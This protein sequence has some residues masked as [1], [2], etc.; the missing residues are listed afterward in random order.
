MKEEIIRIDEKTFLHLTNTDKFKSDTIAVFLLTDLNKDDVTKNALIPAVLRRG[1][2]T[3]TTMKD[4]SI[5][6]D[7]MYG[8]LFDTSV[9]KI[10]DKQAIELYM[11]T[12][13]NKYALDGEDLLS[14]ALNFMYEVIYNPKLVN[15]IFD[16]EY[17]AQEKE[18]LRELIKGKINN[19][20]SYATLRAVEEMFKDDPYALF[21]YGNE[22]DLDK[23]TP[24]ELYA[25]YEN[26]LKTSEKHFYVSG[27][28]DATKVKNFF[29][30]KFLVGDDEALKK[31]ETEY[32]LGDNEVRTKKSN[33]KFEDERNVVE[34]MDVTQGKLV[35]AY[36]VDF[37]LTKENFYK[38]LV[39]NAI[40]GSS[41]NSKLFQNV[42]EK[43]S[44]A[45]TTRSTYLKHKGVLL[46]SAGIE[47]DKYEK[48]LGLI[49]VQVEDMK[50]GNFSD[51]DIKD[52]K[53]FLENLFKSVLDDETA[54]IEF[55]IGNF[56][57]GIKDSIYEIIENV[58][59]ISR[60]DIV[61]VANKL[62]LVT[63]Y[64]L[65]A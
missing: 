23:I 12:I 47:L 30:S 21:K 29:V 11:S 34:K 58:K 1:T 56:V 15:G 55:S 27:N 39:Y 49:K 46:V 41:S 2:K 24:E 32:N 4:I 28:V 44:L 6:M 19:K 40:L 22:A 37:D 43:A 36:D 45:Y 25:Q 7:D 59:K 10:G 51:E 57:L 20:S 60:E 54:M 13:N 16:A 63:N 65:C 62:R 38:M 9:D 35:L 17:V 8:A 61:E 3:L 52:A 33:L 5:K 18:T 26:I 50:R 31:V 14:E 53:V 64:Y 42:R 48:A